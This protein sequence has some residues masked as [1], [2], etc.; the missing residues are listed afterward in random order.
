MAEQEYH[1]IVVG[2]GMAGLTC[3]TYLAREGLNVLLVEKNR[4]C[5]GLVNTFS[6]NGFQFDAGI[7][8]LE[9]AGIIFP[10]L[11]ELGI[12]LDVVK[13]PVS[14]G[15]ENEILNIADIES[16]NEY[17]NLLVKLYP[18]SKAEID[19]IIRIIR[20]IMKHM[21]VL[22]GIEN[23]WF[24][25]TARDL[26]YLF[27]KLLPWLPKFL[28]TIRKINRMNV[29]VEPYLQ[30]I[31][32]N[33]SLL[34]IISQHFFRNT[35]AFFALSYFSLYLDYFYPRGG[36][37]R[38]AGE[39]EQKFLEYGGEIVRETTIEKV[40]AFEKRLS[41]HNKNTYSFKN[42]VWAADLKTFYRITGTEG[43]SRKTR[44]KFE[45]TKSLLLEKRG[46]DSV[47]TLFIEVDEP[48]ESFG[49]ISNG[50]FFY[51]P[52]RKGL[53]DIRWG[54]LDRLLNKPGGPVR[55]DILNWLDKFLALNT[56]EISIPALKDQEMAPEGKTGLIISFLADY[57]LFK[58]IA[59]GGW[60][61][62]FIKELEERIIK[63]L[64]DSIY[65]VLKEKVTEH[66][67]FSPL[68]YEKR[69]GTSGGAITGWSFREPVPVINKI[70]AAN[71]A[72][73]TPLPSIY[74]A[75]QWTYSPAGVPMSILTGKLAALRILSA[76]KPKK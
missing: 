51:S 28:L 70:M 10:M 8:A 45:K 17:C 5:G 55:S 9:N 46:G 24:K 59:D 65:P 2:G 3:A 60:H 33:P 41:D 76:H 25:D 68:S 48:V 58:M 53:G 16:L 71:R 37:G 20:K 52:S 44:M 6:H 62:E 67:S 47:F 64:G 61:E 11:N 54:D 23:P 7:R 42:L 4:E 43:L 49:K 50:H 66:F 75:G 56:Y 69:V 35:P 72:A 21:D 34:D 18:D 29:P 57:D 1:S 36:V 73:V 27:R 22:Y 74:Q 63:L 40:S 32:K 39:V 19:Q 26:N 14:V 13:S 30:K 31:I 12:E 15:V 38:I